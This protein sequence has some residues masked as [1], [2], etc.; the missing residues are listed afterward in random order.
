MGIVLGVAL[1]GAVGATLRYWIAGLIQPSW[2]EG[3]PFGIFVVNITGGLVMGLL[4]ALLA[5]K[6]NVTPEM[7]AFLTTGVLGG[8]TTFSTFSLESAM[9]IERGQWTQAGVY[10]VGSA[11]LSI[12]AIFAGLWI[13]RAF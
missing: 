3:F 4:T 2:W 12:L 5:L 9:L 11:V 7:R 6:M 1:G 8:Y 10:V 13:V